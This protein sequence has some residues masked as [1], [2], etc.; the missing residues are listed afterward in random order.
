MRKRLINYFSFSKQEYNGLMV[1]IVLIMVVMASPYLYRYFCP[2]IYDAVAE[3]KAIQELIL[4]ERDDDAKGKKRNFKNRFE[5]RTKVRLFRFDPNT[6]DAAGWQSLGLSEKQAFAILKYREKGGRFYKAED[7]KKMYTV[8]PVLYQQWLPYIYIGQSSLQKDSAKFYRAAN[9]GR[10]AIRGNSAA[11]LVAQGIPRA[12]GTVSKS[13][14]TA[15]P[16]IEVNG[17]DEARLDEIKGV[18][19]FFAKRII[20]YR[21]RLGGFYH[22]EQLKEVPGLDSL[23]YQE[24]ATQVRIDSALIRKVNINTIAETDYRKLSYF[25]YKQVKAVVQYRKQHGN[26]GNIADL[27]KVVILSPETVDKIAPYISF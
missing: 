25:T 24:I 19:P 2:E 1:M 18:G 16:V 22:K 21:E 15:R 20:Q 9:G 26:Y 12:S 8:S 10:S 3:Q 7:L 17:A 4:V 6:L 11:T 23:K 5:G 14:A 27:K 13:K